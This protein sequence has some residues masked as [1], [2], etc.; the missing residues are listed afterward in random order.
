MADDAR[1]AGPGPDGHGPGAHS[2]AT[3]SA[4]A[5]AG[6]A[7]VVSHLSKTFPG[8]RALRDVSFTVEPGHIHALLGGNGCGKSTLIKILAGVYHGDPGGKFIVGEMEIPSD[9]TS[10]DRA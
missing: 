10:P 3:G 4:T 5:G 7:L 8:T 6:P 2:A 1:T 9:Q